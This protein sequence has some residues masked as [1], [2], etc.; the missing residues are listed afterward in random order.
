MYGYTVWSCMYGYTVWSCMYGCTVEPTSMCRLLFKSAFAIDFRAVLL[1][2]QKFL[3]TV[4]P[5]ILS[6]HVDCCQP[7]LVISLL[8]WI[9]SYPN[10]VYTPENVHLKSIT[11]VLTQL[12]CRY[13][14]WSRNTRI[15]VCRRI[16]RLANMH[17]CQ[18]CEIMKSFNGYSHLLWVC[19]W[20][21]GLLFGQ[22]LTRDT[23]KT[24]VVND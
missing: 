13:R 7:V 18:W 19:I 9:S 10:L 8:S 2:Y 23:R 6:V 24:W 16:T 12:C 4:E 17:E 5:L 1:S 20:L 14:N 21:S 22:R 11:H 15:L 3:T